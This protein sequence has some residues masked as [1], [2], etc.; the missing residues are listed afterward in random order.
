MRC[1][2]AVVLAQPALG[3]HTRRLLD[4]GDGFGDLGLLL[5][6]AHLG[7]DHAVGR[8]AVGDELV[9]ALLELLDEIGVTL[10]GQRVHR[11]AGPYLVTVEHVQHAEDAGPVAVFALRPDAVVG[12]VAAELA[13]MARVLV[14]AR[15]RHQ[16]PIFQM[17]QHEGGDA[18]VARPVELGPQREGRIVVPGIVHPGLERRRVLG[19]GGGAHLTPPCRDAADRVSSHGPRTS[20][21]SPRR[22]RPRRPCACGYRPA[23]GRDV[24]AGAAR[25]SCRGAARCT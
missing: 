10:G 3:P 18:R 21:G 22:C 12:H 4:G 5:G 9:F 16:L 23:P 14:A 8:V 7:G 20:R 17:Q 13:A 11:H 15:V 1:A 6:L 2:L 24:S 19:N 25:P